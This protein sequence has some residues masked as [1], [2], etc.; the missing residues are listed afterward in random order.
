MNM[1][2]SV[3]R[4]IVRLDELEPGSLFIFNKTIAVKSDY[5]GADGACKCF[6]VGTGEYF[7]GG[8]SEAADLNNLMVQRAF[9]SPIK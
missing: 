7:W 9:L 3:A 8:T 2:F 5:R 6:I 1:Q 4:G